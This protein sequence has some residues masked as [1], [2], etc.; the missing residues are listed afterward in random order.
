MVFDGWG[1]V[2]QGMDLLGQDGMVRTDE[3][4][5]H[6]IFGVLAVVF[7]FDVAVIAG[8]YQQALLIIPGRQQATNGFI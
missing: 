2:G 6:G 8:N 3:Q 5:G 7:G 1:D 4:G